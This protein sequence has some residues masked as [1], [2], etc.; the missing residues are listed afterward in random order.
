MK[1]LRFS[2]RDLLWIV[3]VS[4][5]VVGWLCDRGRLEAENEAMRRKLVS[6]PLV[7]GDRME[8]TMEAD[9]VVEVIGYGTT[10]TIVHRLD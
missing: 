5:L 8:A 3:V 4:A 6:W 1:G 9:G 7:P 10:K 2:L